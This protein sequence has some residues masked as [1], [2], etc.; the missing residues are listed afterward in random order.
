MKKLTTTISALLTTLLLTSCVVVINQ[1]AA[2][3][4]ETA[5][6]TMQ[7]SVN[8]ELNQVNQKIKGGN[9]DPDSLKQIVEEAEQVVDKSLKQLSDLKIPEKAQKMATDTKHS[10][11]SAK[12]NFDQLLELAKDLQDLKAQSANASQKTKDQINAQIKNIQ[13]TINE[14]SN[15][16]GRIFVGIDNLGKQ[17]E[18]SY[19][20]LNTQLQSK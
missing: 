1:N 14:V 16:L 8:Q 9:Y 5:M 19:K 2:S 15:Q 18:Q 6:Y 7:K 3:P 4:E 20:Q 13:G 11:E 17:L 10:L 12:R